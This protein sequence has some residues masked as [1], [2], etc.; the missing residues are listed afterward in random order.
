MTTYGPWVDTYFLAMQTGL[1]LA[2]EA[3]REWS[4]CG[5]QLAELGV[6]FAQTGVAVMM[7]ISLASEPRRCPLCAARVT[8]FAAKLFWRDGFRLDQPAANDATWPRGYPKKY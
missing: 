7:P 4:R 6:R 1:R 5:L 2:N 8:N 3:S